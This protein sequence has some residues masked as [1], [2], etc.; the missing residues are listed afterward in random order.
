MQSNDI[1]CVREMIPA[2]ICLF[3]DLTNHII[4]KTEKQIFIIFVSY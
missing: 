1:S 4:G 3:F 2:V